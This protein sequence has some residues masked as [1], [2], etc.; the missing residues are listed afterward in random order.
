MMSQVLEGYQTTITLHV[1]AKLDE[2]TETTVGMA[3]RKCH[4]C[5]SD[6]VNI[7]DMPAHSH[8]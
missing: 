5:V 3:E 7:A 1:W 4:S 8:P 6:R 2:L